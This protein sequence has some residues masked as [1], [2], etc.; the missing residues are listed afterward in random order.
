VIQFVNT[1][2]IQKKNENAECLVSVKFIHNES[3]LHL[4]S[5][6]GGHSI[7][8]HRTA[9]WIL[10]PKGLVEG[11]DLAGYDNASGDYYRV[12]FSAYGALIKGF[13]HESAMSPFGRDD[14]QV[15]P[16]VLASIPDCFRPYVASK[17]L[18]FGVTTFCPWRVTDATSW[19]FGEAVAP[20][21]PRGKYD[22]FGLT[23]SPDGSLE[24]LKCIGGHVDNF[25]Q[26][27]E[28]YWEASIDRSALNSVFH[29]QELSETLLSSLDCSL[30]P[31]IVTRYAEAI[32]YPV[33]DFDMSS[34][35]PLEG[36][37]KKSPETVPTP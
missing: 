30:S 17:E 37:E 26:Y 32:G 10:F 7:R 20:P 4:A 12:L 8:R 24:L 25:R 31:D 6:S 22:T 14:R 2:S 27:A 11:V 18:E 15:W 16:G 9:G 34:F 3:R 28:D 29:H 35:L 5:P 21:S 23:E 36:P 19:Q 13:A 1:I 33:P